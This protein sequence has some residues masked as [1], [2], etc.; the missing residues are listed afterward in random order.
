VKREEGK[1]ERT[2]AQAIAV[3]GPRKAKKNRPSKQKT[4]VHSRVRSNKDKEGRE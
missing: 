3:R 2:Y 1:D 4:P